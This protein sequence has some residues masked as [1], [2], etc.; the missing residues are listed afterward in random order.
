MRGL[1]PVEATVRV[2]MCRGW[3]WGEPHHQREP[4]AQCEW[5]GENLEVLQAAGQDPLPTLDPSP[6]HSP[7]TH[8]HTP[9]PGDLAPQSGLSG[10]PGPAWPL[11]IHPHFWEL[12][13]ETLGSGIQLARAIP[14]LSPLE[15]SD[16]RQTSDSED[17]QVLEM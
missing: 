2:C 9:P 3:G 16:P 8:P 6:Q 11:D 5:W 15:W 7:G 13:G 10:F 17:P 12:V 1:I 4:K 14:W